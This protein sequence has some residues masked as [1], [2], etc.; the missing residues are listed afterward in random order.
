[1]GQVCGSGVCTAYISSTTTIAGTTVSTFASEAVSS[2]ISPNLTSTSSTVITG[3]E[4]VSQLSRTGYNYGG[5]G[6]SSA[7]SQAG[8]TSTGSGSTASQTGASGSGDGLTGR[9]IGGISAGVV[10]GFLLLV[11]LGWL[12]VRHLIRISRFMDKFNSHPR[13][14]PEPQ[15]ITEGEDGT[16]DSE[17]KILNN[18]DE[19]TSGTGQTLAEL[20]PQERPQL[21][22]EWGRHG[23]RGN[24]LSGG[25][26]AHGIS[27]LEG[28]SVSR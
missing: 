19:A 18:G 1:M 21:L 15:P 9:Q 28:K 4:T 2:Q 7:G 12:L 14:K 5:W 23:S 13:D 25:Q 6:G 16:K 11:A 8:V 17:L 27:E 24:E 3:T 10:V 22:D 26:E 20:S